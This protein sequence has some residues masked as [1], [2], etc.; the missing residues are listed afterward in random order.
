MSFVLTENDCSFIL[1]DVNGSL[2]NVIHDNKIIEQNMKLLL[3]LANIL[4]IPLTV[5]TQNASKLGPTLP[6]LSKLFSSDQKEYDKLVFSCL[7][8]PE[9]VKEIQSRNSKTLVLFGIESHICVYQ[10]AIQALNSGYNVVVVTDAVSSRT[11]ENK[12]TALKQLQKAGVNLLSTEMVIY[13]LLGE[14][15]TSNFRTML[16]FLKDPSSA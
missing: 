12:S 1:I 16:P 9:V 14:A 8:V 13:E 11:A 2:F 10:T 5:T 6:S 3:R 7:K 4:N 15:G